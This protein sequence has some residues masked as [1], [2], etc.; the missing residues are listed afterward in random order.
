MASVSGRGVYSANRASALA[1]VPT[2]TVYEWARKGIV[3]PS[4]SPERIKL[5]S[6]ADLV[7]LRAI[8]W[9]RHPLLD[10]RKATA[11]SRVRR[12][13]SVVEAE[14]TRIGDAI[15]QRALILRV[16]RSGRIYIES[17]GVMLDGGRDFKHPV[18]RDLVVDLL[19]TFSADANLT[20][21]DLTHP[22]PQLRI[23]PGKLS[24][25]P[26]VRDTRIETRVLAA[27]DR[28]GFDE[29]VIIDLYPGLSPEALADS[30]DLERQLEVNLS[31][32]A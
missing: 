2:S 6:W 18:A 4:I 13:I 28:R 29:R 5:W 30:I 3:V 22:R 1:G 27:L 15:G 19:A 21:P 23:S 25:E 26:H 14:A 24:G 20:G 16:D 12:F 11:M 31:R 10:N 7:A 8:Y 9:L 32:A 17:D